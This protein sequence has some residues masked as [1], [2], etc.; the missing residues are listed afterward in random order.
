[1]DDSNNVAPQA[2]HSTRGQWR[3]LTHPGT[4]F[5]LILLM[6]VLLGL[7]YYGYQQHQL[8]GELEALRQEGMPTDGQELNDY[9]AIP[10]GMT[11]STQA[12]L[13]AFAAAEVAGKSK[14]ATKL[15]IIGEGATPVPRRGIPWGDLEGAHSFLN[16]SSTSLA[17][18]LILDAAAQG[19]ASRFPA[20][21]NAGTQTLLP[22]LQQARSATRL[23]AL[24]AHVACHEGDFTRMLEDARGLLAISSSLQSEP[25]IISQL[26]R[27][28]IFVQA[29]E[30]IEAGLSDARWTDTELQGLQEQIRLED[31]Q[32]GL[33]YAVIGERAMLQTAIEGV[34]I[35]PARVFLK[36][37]SLYLWGAVLKGT[38]GTWQEGKDRMDE[39]EA[40]YQAHPINRYF[41][42]ARVLDLWIGL[43]NL[44]FLTGTTRAEARQ[45]CLNL[46]I[47]AQRYRLVHGTFPQTLDEIDPEWI[48]P[49]ET[50]SAWL[51]DPFDN[52]PLRY[53]DEADRVII[54]SVGEDLTDDGGACQS[55]TSSR[56][57]D[58]GIILWKGPPEKP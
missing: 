28:A 58:V 51:T 2:D 23:L 7:A 1:M 53:K 19:G 42:I 43:P 50:R 29:A 17:R 36:R 15:P 46:G 12:W 45:R 39:L 24:D 16:T 14:D 41:P 27:Y 6:P 37:Y 44:Q 13:D 11:D 33:K 56:S 9:Y 40:E 26:V 31:F 18:Q 34:P 30:V 3:W 38:S 21:F 47:A 8:R 48:A 52:A 57:Q 10:A 55:G 49:A 54:Y 4:I 32:A 22:H 20:D 25:V 5:L 35:G